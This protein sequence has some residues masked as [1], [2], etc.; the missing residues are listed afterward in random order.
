VIIIGVIV[1]F[2]AIVLYMTKDNTAADD[3]KAGDCFDI[4]TGDTVKTV[5]HHACTEPHTAEVFHVV[6]YSG[7]DMTTPI[8]LVIDQFASTACEPVFATYVGKAAAAMPDLTIGYFYPTADGWSRG[9]RTITCY[10][11]KADESSMSSSLK[12]S[13]GP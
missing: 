3:L 4:P 6:E 2:L 10:V 8:T 1:A 11:S 12:G 9:D 5:V 13:A 7:S